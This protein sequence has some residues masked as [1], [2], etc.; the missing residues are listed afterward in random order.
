MAAI[1]SKALRFFVPNG[2]IAPLPPRR[3]ILG[4]SDAKLWPLSYALRRAIA[5][6]D[7]IV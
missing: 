4:S 3:L 5:D 1:D 6:I 7:M 2:H